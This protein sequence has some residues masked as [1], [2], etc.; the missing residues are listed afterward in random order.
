MY[1]SKYKR[2]FATAGEKRFHKYKG[3][4]TIDL[5]NVSDKGFGTSGLIINPELVVLK[6][7]LMH[8]NR[9]H[10]KHKTTCKTDA[11]IPIMKHDNV[12]ERLLFP[13]H[14]D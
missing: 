2:H 12:V 1:C 5:L 9:P 3:S 4:S 11:R 10:E 14:I 13:S 7:Y 6:H 8:E